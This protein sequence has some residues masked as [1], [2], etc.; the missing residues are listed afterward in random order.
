MHHFPKE[1][2]PLT[3]WS[4]WEAFSLRPTG[5]SLGVISARYSLSFHV[6]PGQKGLCLFFVATF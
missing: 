5:I 1:I 2:I 4:H 3:D 6:I